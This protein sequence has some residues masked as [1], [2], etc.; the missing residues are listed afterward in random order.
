MANL[1]S[2][3]MKRRIGEKT[4]IGPT[5]IISNFL[6]LLVFAINELL[7]AGYADYLYA[8]FR[9]AHNI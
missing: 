3:L 9:L 8:L 2:Y 4:R 1:P 7:A 6:L 5:V